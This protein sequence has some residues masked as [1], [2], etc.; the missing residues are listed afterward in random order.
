VHAGPVV[1]AAP[2]IRRSLAPLALLAATDAL[3]VSTLARCFDGP[4]ELSLLV[5]TCLAVHLL[6]GVLRR[7][8]RSGGIGTL[9]GYLAAVVVGFMLPLA[10]L[11]GGT[12]SYGVLPLAGTWHVVAG[13][14]HVAWQ[15]F[16]HQLAPVAE[17]PGL[18]LVAGWAAA[19]LALAAEILYADS[20]LP[21][22]L[23]LVP[24]FDIVVFSG[25]LGTATGRAPEIA[26]V[27]A[28]GVAFL[29][30][31]QDDRRSGPSVVMARIEAARSL[32]GHSGRLSRLPSRGAL[33]GIA[34]AAA[35]GAGIIGPLLPGATS[36]PLVAWHGT[37]PANTGSAG[38]N[39]SKGSTNHIVVSTL[40]EVGQQLIENPA[41]LLLTVHSRL[42]TREVLVALDRFN[43]NEWS[44]LS[45]VGKFDSP[46]AIPSL[47]G[48]IPQLTRDPPP[49][50]AGTGGSVVATEVIRIG[51]LGGQFLPAP[52]EALAVQGAGTV[53]RLSGSGAL[54]PSAQLD[55]G[56]LYAI[57]SE[58]PPP[59]PADLSIESA[60]QVRPPQVDLQLPRPVPQRIVALARRLVAGDTT[61]YDEAVSLQ[62]Y[63]QRN[64]FVYHLPTRLAPASSTGGEGYAALLHFLFVS[65]SGYC[66]QYASAFAVMARA[67]GL[68][69]RVAVGFLPGRSI[70]SDAFIVTGSEVHAW[71]QVLLGKA[72]WVDFEPTPGTQPSRQDPGGPT[73]TTAP[74]TSV[75]PSQT[76]HTSQPRENL[77][78]PKG[79]AAAV[80]RHRSHRGLSRSSSASSGVIDVLLALLGLGVVWVI[81]VPALRILLSRRNRRDPRQATIEAW[82]SATWVLAAAGIH[83]RRSETHR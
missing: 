81:T 33:P 75:A 3:A 56:L 55:N 39:G 79:G 1:N 18:V 68:P 58:L 47:A 71:P 38:T 60:F 65:K 20:G 67:V 64:G 23:A 15:I 12:L 45:G 6:A 4:G 42:R 41:T 24:A 43:G 8:R 29:L 27:A 26:G 5:P 22:I 48:S 54:V 49:V 10:F 66:Q 13:Q 7:W 30:V 36:A 78:K 28:L 31:A 25:T 34:L 73:T 46:Y 21:A 35:A 82:R 70:G 19:V 40:V 76:T 59:S 52:G 63:F 14:F 69:T 9:A 11:D 51:A 61:P 44:R 80:V 72:G 74:S 53:S 37:R 17:Q 32:P 77:G 57:Q 16:S 62:A 50:Q 83:R 2:A